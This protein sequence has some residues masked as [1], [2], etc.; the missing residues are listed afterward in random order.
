MTRNLL[1]ETIED[2]QLAGLSPSDVI[3]VT[4]G[5]HS[6]SWEVF[7]ARAA[8]CNYDAGFGSAEVNLHLKVVGSGWWLE[9]HEYDGAESWA[10][11]R[12]P[13]DC[14][15]GSLVL[16]EPDLFDIDDEED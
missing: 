13:E 12:P 14:P 4:D 3:S 6:C 7:A 10:F 1:Q 5:K 8:S 2:L 11:K 9:R 16:T 15:W